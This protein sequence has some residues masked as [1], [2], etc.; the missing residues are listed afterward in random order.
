MRKAATLERIEKEVETLAP[1]EQLALV[2]RVVHQ[3]RKGRRSGRRALSWQK[4]YGL[5]KGIWRGEDAQD[6]VNRLR[7]D[8]T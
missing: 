5:G 8:R 6:Y 7:E 2:E 1:D 3:L 4:L